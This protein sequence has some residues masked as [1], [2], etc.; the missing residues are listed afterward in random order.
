MNMKFRNSKEKKSLG[1]E[2]RAGFAFVDD[3]YSLKRDIDVGDGN[4]LCF[5]QELHYSSHN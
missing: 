2:T 4:I 5:D 1:I 3:V